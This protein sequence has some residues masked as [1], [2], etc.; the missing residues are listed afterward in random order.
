MGWSKGFKLIEQVVD[1]IEFQ[2]D[3]HGLDSSAAGKNVSLQASV[4]YSESHVCF[5][6][7][8]I[9]LMLDDE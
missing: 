4:D 8:L 3:Y 5:S 7:K 1:A 9:Q 6:I 2:S